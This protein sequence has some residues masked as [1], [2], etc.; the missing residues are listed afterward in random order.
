MYFDLFLIL[1]FLLVTMFVITF[2][3]YARV[4]KQLK[5]SHVYKWKDLGQQSIFFG[6]SIKNNV[7]MF[8][9]LKRKEYLSLND[10]VLS[11]KCGYLWLCFRIYILV[12]I[13]TGV[14]FFQYVSQAR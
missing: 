2:F 1:L 4:L 5:N 12:F 10:P 7:A 6:N 14:L 8:L 9:F 13:V 11:T 3:F